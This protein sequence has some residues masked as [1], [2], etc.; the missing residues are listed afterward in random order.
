MAG[1]AWDDDG[2]ETDGDGRVRLRAA[3]CQ[4]AMEIAPRDPFVTAGAEFSRRAV[5]RRMTAGRTL[6]STRT[7]EPR[8]CGRSVGP[9]SRPSCDCRPR[10]GPGA[11]GGCDGRSEGATSRAGR[12]GR[13]HVR[14]RFPAGGGIL[15]RDAEGRRLR[16]GRDGPTIGRLPAAVDQ[17]RRPAAGRRA[18][19]GRAD[20]SPRPD[21]R[22]LEHAHAGQRLRAV[23]SGQGPRRSSTR[24]SCSVISK[25]VHDR[26]RHPHGRRGPGQGV[27]P[28]RDLRDH[29]EDERSRAVPVR[30]ED[31][32]PHHRI[33]LDAAGGDGGGGARRPR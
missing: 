15:A 11:G 21:M 27:R 25:P 2:T 9:P 30:A 12:G 28:D 14:N 4:A 7:V 16:V 1:P 18:R 3:S 29:R 33:R 32:G 31:Q 23:P 13:G 20:R 8:A 5:G 26:H 24:T 6:R 10:R 22:E 17:S 19:M